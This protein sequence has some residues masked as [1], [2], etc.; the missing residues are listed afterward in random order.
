VDLRFLCDGRAMFEAG[1]AMM[2]PVMDAVMRDTGWEYDG[3]DLVLC[4]EASRRFVDHGM[5]RVSSHGGPKTWSTVARFGNTT[6]FSLPLQMHEARDAGVLHAGARVL[7]LGGAAGL[8]MAAM[9]W[10]W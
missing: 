10:R 5:E 3:L 7:M 6:T 4:H 1:V 2:P 9:T 8:S